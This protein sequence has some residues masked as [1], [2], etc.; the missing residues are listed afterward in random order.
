MSVSIRMP[1]PKLFTIGEYLTIE[2]KAA[3][4]SEFHEGQI[5]AMPGGTPEHS[6]IASNVGSELT[7]QLKGRKCRAYNSDLRQAVASGESAYYADVSVICGETKLH[8]RHRDLV[9]NSAL[10]V[11]V[12]SQST[13]R[14]D[15]LV[16]VPKYQ[17]T[18]SI[19][20][21]LLVAQ[22]R[23]RVEHFTRVKEDWTAME[24]VKLTDVIDLPH[25]RCTLA[26]ADVYANIEF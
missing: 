22:D 3:T 17:R 25:L 23:P 18:P 19:K 10:V 5:L 14:Y 26:L 2:R 8:G 11:E 1:Q 4:K 9:S 16:K 13:A 7:Q 24:Y 21:I 20:D 15:R 12:L 6:L